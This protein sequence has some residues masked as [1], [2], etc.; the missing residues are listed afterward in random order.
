MNRAEK[1]AEVDFLSDCLTKSQIALCAEYRGLSV[2]KMTQ[3]R[4]DLR[5]AGSQGRVVKNT[6]ARISAARALKGRT[7]SEVEQFLDLLQGPVL[8]IYS[9]N[10]PVEPTKVV[11]KFAK[12]NEKLQIRGAFVDGEF[13]DA[14]GVDV[15]SKMPGKNELLSQLLRVINAPAT[16]LVRLL[17]APATQVV[18]V[19]DAHR[20]NMEGK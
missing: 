14:K 12:D 19:L 2:A 1:Q 13:V 11:A 15:L 20:E 17:H 6:L 3:L 8:M 16:N 5:A 7:S 18:R 10:D 4:R 9:F